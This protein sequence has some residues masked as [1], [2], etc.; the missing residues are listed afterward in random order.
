MLCRKE[1]G[2][3]GNP[4]RAFRALPVFTALKWH[5]VGYTDSLRCWSD[6]ILVVSV[7][8]VVSAP[9]LLVLL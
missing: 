1:D 4:E 5:I 3:Y 8:E 2:R 7:I 6:K 9:K